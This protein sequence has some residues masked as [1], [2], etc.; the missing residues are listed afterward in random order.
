M[1]KGSNV[2]IE[3][4]GPSGSGKTTI[5]KKVEEVVNRR[6]NVG[7]KTRMEMGKKNSQWVKASEA[8]KAFLK[9]P[10]VTK[11]VFP[12][13][14]KGEGVKTKKNSLV[15]FFRH[16]GFAEMSKRYNNVLIIGD[17]FILSGIYFK[18]TSKKVPKKGEI[19]EYVDFSD[20]FLGGGKHKI[21]VIDSEKNRI[22]ERRKKRYKDYDKKLFHD[23]KKH[24]KV[25]KNL[26]EVNKK[27][28]EVL[29]EKNIPFIEVENNKPSDIEKAAN[30]IVKFIEPELKKLE[31]KTKR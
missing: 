10:S 18:V 12:S 5:A 17:E 8:I 3:F 2:I 13:A 7:I 28:K 21:V 29:E 11:F 26:K 19:K 6:Y 14:V 24:K 25:I 9:N 30:K 31:R 22:V 1:G 27:L 15:G 23:L 4:I 16:L 20:S